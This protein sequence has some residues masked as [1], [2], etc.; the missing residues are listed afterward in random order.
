MYDTAAQEIDRPPLVGARG[1]PQLDPDPWTG[2]RGLQAIAIAAARAAA[3]RPFCKFGVVGVFDFQAKTCKKPFYVA[4]GNGTSWHR[5]ACTSR[6]RRRAQQVCRLQAAPLAHVSPFRAVQQSVTSHAWAF[7]VC[8][9]AALHGRQLA[10]RVDP[11]HIQRVWNPC[12]PATPSPPPRSRSGASAPRSPRPPSRSRSRFPRLSRLDALPPMRSVRLWQR[13]RHAAG[14]AVARAAPRGAGRLHWGA[15][16]GCLGRGG[17]GRK[18]RQGA[19]RVVLVPVARGVAGRG[20]ASR[21]RRG[22]GV[23]GTRP[24]IS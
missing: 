17:R 5:H 20:A 2:T 16:V 22:R 8:V 7:P 15:P 18:G 10:A 24:N 23:L 1:R 4:H 12:A 11:R 21:P 3:A 13:A 19:A 6:A 14:A 9:C